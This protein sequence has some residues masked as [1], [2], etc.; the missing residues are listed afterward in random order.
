MK[1]RG[2]LHVIVEGAKEAFAIYCNELRAIFSDA[3]VLI[4]FFLAGLLY[5]ILYGFVYRNET[6]YNVPIA[7]VDCSNSSLSRQFIRHLDATPDVAVAFQVPTMA[8]AQELYKRSEVNGVVY[9]PKSFSDDVNSG[10][11]TH[12]SAYVNMASMIYYKAVYSA[13]NYVSLDM[14]GRIQVGNLMARGESYH[15]AVVS[16]SPATY[17]VVAMFNPKSGYASFLIPCVLILVIQQTLVL[18]VGI[19]SGTDRERNAYHSLLPQLRM[20]HGTIRS[21]IGRGMA[22]FVIYMFIGAYNMIVIPYLFDLPHLASFA[23]IISLLIPFVLAVTFFSMAVSVFFYTREEV[24]LMFLFTSVPLLFLAGAPWPVEN[25]PYFWRFFSAFFPS[26]FCIRAFVKL[27]SMGA[28]LGQVGFEL[29]WLWIQAGVYFLVALL[30]FR[31]QIKES[32]FK[33]MPYVL[34]A[35]R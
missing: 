16:A 3:G 11:Q 5:P 14:G 4:I 34:N 13:V 31:W 28:T 22:Y 32:Y 35:D 18:G 9:I 10:I 29:M 19:R 23:E 21:V 15:E 27:N 25:M 6:I 7:V 26:T 20:Y 8:E 30:L 2:L 24:F 17:D 12:V 1:E 33:K